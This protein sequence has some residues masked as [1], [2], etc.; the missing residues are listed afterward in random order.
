M[1][2][3]VVLLGDQFPMPNQ[4]GLRRDNGGDLG[5][6]PP[7]QRFGLNRQSPALIIIE[8]QSSATELL[9]KNPVLLTKV[10]DDLQ[11]TLIHPTGNGDQHKPEWVEISLGLQSSL[12]RVPDTGETIADPCRSSFRTIR[13]ETR[14]ASGFTV[15]MHAVRCHD[16]LATVVNSLLKHGADAKA[17]TNT[18]T[19]LHLAVERH[20]TVNAKV[21]QLL[22]DAG[23]DPTLKD[24][25]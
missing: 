7:P 9:A 15:L 10:I 13:A 20:K 25:Y 23:A 6:N 24:A 12:S 3:S 8:A 19:V 4:Q 11:L 18:T 1:C 14:D 21:V 17:T 2:R 5:Q 16:Q 22:L